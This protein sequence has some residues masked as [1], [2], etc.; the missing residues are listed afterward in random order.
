M[1]SKRFLATAA[2]IGLMA[3]P[4]LAQTTPSSPAAQ[5]T[6]PAPSAAAPVSKKTNLNSATAEE[7]EVLPGFDKARAKAIL[8]ERSK[9][10]FKD[11]AD[12]DKRMTGASITADAKT[13]I[14]D[15]VTF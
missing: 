15:R 2:L 6:T 7:I 9:G 8:D 4:T 5:A 14:Q 11:W 1:L 10:K 13:K 3:A 12:F